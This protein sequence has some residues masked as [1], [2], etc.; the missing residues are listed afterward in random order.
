MTGGFGS[1]VLELDRGGAPGRPGLPRRRRPDRRHPGR[2]VRRPRLG[3]GPAARPAARRAGLAEQVRETLATLHGTPERSEV[4]GGL[5]GR[6]ARVTPDRAS[7]EPREPVAGRRRLARPSRRDPRRRRPSAPRSQRDL[8]AGWRPHER[9]RPRTPAAHDRGSR[10]QSGGRRRRRHRGE[11]SSC[12]P[13]KTGIAIASRRRG[14]EGQ[15]TVQSRT[16]LPAAG[17]LPR[18]PEC[19]P[20]RA[21]AGREASGYTW[22]PSPHAGRRRA[23]TRSRSR[24]AT[25]RHGPVVSPRR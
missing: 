17:W 4:S 7:S 6:T 21:D 11:R 12:R 10:R 1:G 24:R 2:P 9:R 22:R 23:R 16:R 13:S 18:S 5:I 3:R 15:R 25:G 8:S 19:R 14:T 20:R